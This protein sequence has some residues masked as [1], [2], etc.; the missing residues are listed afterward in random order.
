VE[1]DGRRRVLVCEDDNML[2]VTLERGLRRAGYLVDSVATG[3]RAVE[4]A[5]THEPDAIVLDIGLPDADGRDVCQAI[6]A[7]GSTAG[8][9]FLT[10]RHH[11]DDLVSGFAVGGDDYVRKPFDFAELLAR[12]EGAI[13]RARA[14]SAAPGHPADD[15]EAVES[16]EGRLVLDPSAHAIRFDGRTA[17]LTPTEFRFLACLIRRRPD[18]VRRGELEA[19]GWP[20]VDHVSDN[21]VDQYIARSR[22]KLREIDFPGTIENIRS[23][24][25]RLG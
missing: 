11:T 20:G 12:V 10:A 22:R 18:V 1:D 13:R 15:S 5:R 14:Q 17:R 2:R 16:W 4:S 19:A 8:I 21:T 6:R 7:Q 3:G 25:Y 9:V 24:G 23:V